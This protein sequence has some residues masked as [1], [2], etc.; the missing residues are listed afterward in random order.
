[1][2][3]F[4]GETNLLSATVVGTHDGLVTLDTPA[5]QLETAPHAPPPPP[6]APATGGTVTCSIRPEAVRVLSGTAQPPAKGARNTIR[7][8]LIQTVYLGEMTQHH[9]KLTDGSLFKALQLGPGEVRQPGAA[10]SLTV[11]P[12]DIVLL[13]D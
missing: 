10:V 12:A 13:P 1:M 7:G 6:P 4:L 11:D 5:G 8:R 9:V 2:A 3:G